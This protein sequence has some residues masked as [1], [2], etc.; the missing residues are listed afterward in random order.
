M[1]ELDLNTGL[2]LLKAGASYGDIATSIYG[3]ASNNNLNT[4]NAI[5]G[6]GGVQAA[7]LSGIGSGIGSIGDLG[8]LAYGGAMGLGGTGATGWEGALQGVTG[9]GMYPSLSMFPYLQGY[10]SPLQAT[11]RSAVMPPTAQP[12]QAPGLEDFSGIFNVPKTSYAI[13]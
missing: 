12:Y 5:I 10:Q 6:R 9:M 13:E 11:Y 4:S 3:L 2:N 7:Q 8:L 1:N